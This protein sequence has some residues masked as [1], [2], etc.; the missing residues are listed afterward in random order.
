MNITSW[1]TTAAGILPIIGAVYDL[2]NMFV[3][4]G[5]PDGTKL[6][7]DLGLLSSGFIGFFAKDHNVSNSP[8]PA[9]AKTVP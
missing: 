7:L 4:G 3:G 1:K 5:T 8:T 9:A 2:G 6:M